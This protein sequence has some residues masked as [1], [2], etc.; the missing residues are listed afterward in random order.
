[1]LEPLKKKTN[2][3]DKAEHKHKILC[4]QKYQA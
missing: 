3:E 1:M 2:P 4:Y